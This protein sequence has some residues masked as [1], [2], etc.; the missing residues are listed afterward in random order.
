MSDSL[1]QLEATA[2]TT[3]GKRV[4]TRRR[5]GFVPGNIIA[6]GQ[7][8]QAIEVP[9]APL[10]KALG[11][12]GRTQPLQLILQKNQFTVLVNEVATHPVT[13][14]LQHVVFLNVEQGKRVN[15]SIPLVLEGDAPGEQKGLLVLQILH[16]LEVVALALKIPEKITVNISQLEEH[17]DVVRIVDLQLP[18]D[19]DVDLDEQT[20]IV[21]LEMSRS[22][23]S[24]TAEAKEDEE[25]EAEATDATSTDAKAD[26]KKDETSE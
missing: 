10:V 13:D 16:Q 25:G 26:E 11:Q 21:K 15:A 4:R 2:R 9:Q 18:P 17:G 5:D 3:L 12:V 1:I 14:A 24:Q 22:Q 20:A 7:A 6:K 8:S 19:I 23:V